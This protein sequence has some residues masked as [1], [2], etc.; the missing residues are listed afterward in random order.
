[1]KKIVFI[2]ESLQCG[3]AEKSLITLLNSLDYRTFQVDLILFKNGGEFT[4]FVPKEVAI[5]H[6][7]LFKNIS[8]FSY[9]YKKTK[10][11]F[12][13]NINKKIHSARFFWQV[14]NTLIEKDTDSYDI[15]I[16][17]NQGFSTY[18]LTNKIKASKK[19]AWI[20]TDYQKA[21]YDAKF[22][23]QFYNKLSAVVGVSKESQQSFINA[24]K[25]YDL[26]AELKV[27]PD[28]TDVSLIKEKAN[29]VIED[30]KFN[31][32]FINIVTVGR[33]TEAKGYQLAIQTCKNLIN[34]GISLKWYI[35]GEGSE[36]GKLESLIKA[37]DL[38]GTFNLMGYQENPYPFINACDIYVQTSVFEGLPLTVIEASLLNK[39]IVST[40]FP[41][42]FGFIKDEET[43]LISEMNAVSI[44]KQVERLILDKV[45]RNKLS[46][47]LSC[48]DNIDKEDSLKEIYK[49]FEH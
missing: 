10:F 2:I 42:I 5:K 17:Y 9:F 36:R 44:T 11:W 25:N 49:L 14:Y 37:N 35:I 23:F 47:N 6:K 39:P 45:L 24:F 31:T 33:L 18:Y 19:I 48:R 32:N 26:S 8:F 38:T 13:R 16:A 12:L 15:A 28:I 30:L 40:N 46:Q 4:K 3:G 21:K 27:I 20:N 34:K 7:Q 41:S 22:D 1:M 29:D 43:G